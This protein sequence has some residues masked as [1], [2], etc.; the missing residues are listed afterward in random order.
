MRINL[1]L[2][3]L[4]IR[5][6]NKN[7]KEERKFAK[8]DFCMEILFKVYYSQIQFASTFVFFLKKKKA[9]GERKRPFDR[10]QVEMFSIRGS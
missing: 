3:E 9:D 7:K 1:E 8:D 4:R 10:A 5:N 6:V 2:Y